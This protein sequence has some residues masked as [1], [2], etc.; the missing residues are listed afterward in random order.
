MDEES[1][2]TKAYWRGYVDGAEHGTKEANHR[3]SQ[4]LLALKRMT[5]VKEIHHAID[6]KLNALHS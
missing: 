4:T 3:Y 5:T 6:T 1:P 2:E